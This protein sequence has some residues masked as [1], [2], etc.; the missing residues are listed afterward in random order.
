MLRLDFET[1]LEKLRMSAGVGVGIV[2]ATTSLLL[3]LLF[4]SVRTSSILNEPFIDTLLFL[5]PITIILGSAFSFLPAS[6]G[7]YTLEKLIQKRYKKRILT[8]KWA[9]IS[10]V[11]LAGFAALLICGMGLVYMAFAPHNGWQFLLNDMKDGVFFANLP[12]YIW[13]IGKQFSHLLS[14]IIIAIILACISGGFSGKYLAR[15]EGK[16]G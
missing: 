16:N 8:E 12:G 14:E 9:I 3:F 13:G 11:L 5:T 15:R 10:G 4:E 1:V 6:I 7:G 2:S